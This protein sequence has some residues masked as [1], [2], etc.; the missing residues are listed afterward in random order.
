MTSDNF[1]QS[2]ASYKPQAQPRQFLSWKCSIDLPSRNSAQSR[3]VHWQN[4]SVY[5]ST[6]GPFS[7]A[8]P[9]YLSPLSIAEKFRAYLAQKLE[10]G[11]VLTA[12]G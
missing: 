7:K 1:D 9:V 10:P 12:K 8:K 5:R 3:S 4:I 11:S 2:L 6:S